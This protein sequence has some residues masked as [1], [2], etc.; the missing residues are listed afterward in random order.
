MLNQLSLL[1]RLGLRVCAVALFMLDS[2][3]F[4]QQTG[5]LTDYPVKPLRILVASSRGTANDFFARSVGR[6]LSA[7]YG[8]EVTVE[9]RPG[10]G[11]MI[12]NVLVSKAT[13]D[14]Y[15]LGM[16]DMTRIVTK[17]MRAPPPYQAVAD[18]TGVAQ[19]ASITYV[20]VA[21][22]SIFARNLADFIDDA[23]SRSSE[24]NYASLGIGSASHLAG[25]LFTRALGIEAMHVPFQKLSRSIVD[26]RRGRVHYAVLTL[27]AVLSAVNEGRIRAMAVMAD[28]RNPALPGVPAIAEAGLPDAE[29]Y[30]WSG[31]VAPR[32]TPRRVVEQLHGDVVSALR[33]AA[34]HDLF[35]RH[36]AQ[37]TPDSTPE[38]FM[39]LIQDEYLRLQALLRERGIKAE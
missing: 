19:V 3:S 13:P 1:V 16:I 2:Q 30:S 29:F 5:T 21:P 37:P 15:T 31:I 14:G 17:L 22:H 10:A 11:G 20:L 36:G 34:V 6:E 35:L 26:I 9:N 38:S 33:K 18:I 27:P 4:A 28:Q 23:R 39:Q 32:G 12:G 25:E 7:F 24:L 8:K